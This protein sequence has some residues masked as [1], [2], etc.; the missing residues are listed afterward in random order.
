M[1]MGSYRLEGGRFPE[2]SETELD[3][4]EKK[5]ASLLG[6]KEPSSKLWKKMFEEFKASGEKSVGSYIER[7]CARKKGEVE[8]RIDECKS[9]RPQ[10]SE[11]E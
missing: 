8:T 9:L 4:L 5:M 3:T 1:K 10:R 7:E 6:D 2:M 11:R